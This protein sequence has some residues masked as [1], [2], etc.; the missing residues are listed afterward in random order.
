MFVL[1]ILWV[2]SVFKTL[3]C[4]NLST[5]VTFITRINCHCYNTELEMICLY[6]YIIDYMYICNI[7]LKQEPG[8]TI[9]CPLRISSI[10][11]TVPYCAL[12][13]HTVLTV[14]Y[15]TALQCAVLYYTVLYCAVPYC[16][17][18]YCAP[19]RVLYYTVLYRA[20]PY[21]TVPYCT[22][23]CLNVPC[24]TVLYCTVHGSVVPHL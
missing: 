5:S 18:P 2:H 9:F 15:C 7:K 11:F 19:M 16:T 6:H 14:L 21:C 23:L 1:C 17:V 12:P 10:S 20:M 3:L 8:D 24:C 4:H 22:V 13:Y